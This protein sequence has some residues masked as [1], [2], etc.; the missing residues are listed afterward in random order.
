MYTSV[1][2]T[3]LTDKYK[4]LIVMYL[5]GELYVP[6]KKVHQHNKRTISV[7]DVCY[8]QNTS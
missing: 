7:R 3:E 6:Q 2:C 4:I 8:L 5:L 1:H